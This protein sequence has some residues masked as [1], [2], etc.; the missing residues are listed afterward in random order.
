MMTMAMMT[1]SGN[2]GLLFFISS[3]PISFY[4]RGGIKRCVVFFEIGNSS[5]FS[6]RK[7]EF[8]SWPPAESRHR[9]GQPN[10]GCQSGPE[11]SWQPSQHPQRP[12]CWRHQRRRYR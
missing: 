3:L 12:S 8:T 9:P 4:M 6:L 11:P 2:Q 1:V 5:R 7:T 10:P